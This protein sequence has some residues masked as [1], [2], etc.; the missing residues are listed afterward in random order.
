MRSTCVGWRII[1][2]LQLL[3]H[4]ESVTLSMATQKHRSLR[5]LPLKCE[6]ER[7]TE[8][9][10]FEIAFARYFGCDEKTGKPGGTYLGRL[11]D[12]P[13]GDQRI[14]ERSVYADS[15]RL[16]MH[17]RRKRGVLPEYILKTHR[18]LFRAHRQQIKKQLKAKTPFVAQQS[19]NRPNRMETAA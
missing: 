5:G 17:G 7:L 16:N 10:V 8:I 15:M 1:N 12:T 19:V 11:K 18:E 14:Y 3:L 13:N 9:K 6:E 4:V 2:Q